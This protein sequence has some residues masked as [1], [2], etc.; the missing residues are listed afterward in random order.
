VEAEEIADEVDEVVVFISEVA[1]VVDAV[2]VDIEVV[3]FSVVNDGDSDKVTYDVEEL[4]IVTVGEVDAED[5]AD[6]D[7]ETT[8]AAAVEVE[9]NA[10]DDEEV[11]V[12]DKGE[13][14]DVGIVG[15]K[16]GSEL[17]SSTVGQ[18]AMSTVVASVGRVSTG[19]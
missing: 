12:D 16:V 17:H 10:I 18:V 2:E 9:A 8:V 6:E 4:S 13:L 15:T 19:S 1:G 3:E 5:V 14:V 7:V 11:I